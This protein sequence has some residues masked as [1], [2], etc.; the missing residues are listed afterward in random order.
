MAKSIQ[1]TLIILLKTIKAKGEKQKAN[2]TLTFKENKE[3]INDIIALAKNKIE[4]A[5][6]FIA[7]SNNTLEVELSKLDNQL[8]SEYQDLL[9]KYAMLKDQRREIY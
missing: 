7:N 9:Q 1:E 6:N 8:E 5:N 2:I 3:D 4:R